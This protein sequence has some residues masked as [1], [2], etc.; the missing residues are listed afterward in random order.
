[1]WYIH[2]GGLSVIKKNEIMLCV[3]KWMELEIMLSELSQSHKDS[4]RIFSFICGISS[5]GA[6]EYKRGRLLEM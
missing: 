4:C 2:S 1:M 3:G 5:W 6:H